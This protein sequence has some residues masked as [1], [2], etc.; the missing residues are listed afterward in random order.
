MY[1]NSFSNT[2]TDDKTSLGSASHGPGPCT[3]RSVHSPAYCWE[4]RKQPTTAVCSMAAVSHGF[5]KEHSITVQASS[6]ACQVIE[7]GQA[8]LGADARASAQMDTSKPAACRFL[9]AAE[10]QA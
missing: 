9:R 10:L 2:I 8:A 3:A 5:S 6:P 4:V 1:L 7:R